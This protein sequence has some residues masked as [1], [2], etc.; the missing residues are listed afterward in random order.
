M[1]Q[2]VSKKYSMIMGTIRQIYLHCIGFVTSVIISIVKIPEL[3]KY[4]KWDG[5]IVGNWFTV[6]GT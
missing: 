2:L 3:Q 1:K 6:R 4:N 5:K